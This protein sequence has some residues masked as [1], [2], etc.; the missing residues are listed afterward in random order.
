VALL[1]DIVARGS[2]ESG[3]LVPVLKEWV[4]FSGTL[5]VVHLA[6]RLLTPKVRVFR[7]YLIEA[8]S[9]GGKKAARSARAR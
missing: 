5:Y 3:A 6:S 9:A 2:V 4:G 1:P 8:L 7:D